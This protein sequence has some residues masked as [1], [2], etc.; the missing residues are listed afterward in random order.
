MSPAYAARNTLLDA[1]RSYHAQGEVK[2]AVAPTSLHVAQVA[3]INDQV[4]VLA[5][6]ISQFAGT[7][8]HTG[9]ISGELL[10]EI[11]V[12]GVLI[13]HSERRQMGEDNALLSL[14]LQQALASGLNVVWCVGETLDQR[15]AGQAMRVVEQQL[16]PLWSQ[17][18]ALQGKL[19]VA[20]EPVW[21][22]G[23]GRTAQVRDAQQMHLHIQQLLMTHE[24]SDVPVLYGG[25]VKPDNAAAL[26]AA[27][28]ING[29][30]VGGAS[31][32]WAS[33]QAIIDAFANA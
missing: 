20:Y 30:L 6:D 29:V 3:L 11:G 24:L 9:E 19:W 28:E 31:L 26:A 4:S 15:E 21:A 5:Q 23:T 33:F 7:G 14:K 10:T 27:P 18:K 12:M 8:A 17:V 1:M 22:I 16:I 32:E 2:V 25:S 13:G